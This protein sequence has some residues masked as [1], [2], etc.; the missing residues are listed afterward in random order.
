MT[1]RNDELEDMKR[2]DLAQYVASRGF[3]LDRRQSSRSS[4][5]MK[6]PSG[7]KLIIAKTSNGQFVYFNAKGNDN[8]TIID[9]IQARDRVSLGE[10]RKLLRLWLA[11]GGCS[12]SNLPTLPIVLQPSEH[13]A[14]Q[15]LTN[16][17]N[18]RPIG[19]TNAYLE[20]ERFI[21]AEIIRQPIFRDRIRVDNRNNT[22]FAHFNQSG[23]CGYEIK[24]TGWTGFAPGGI[25]G[26]ACS[27]PQPEDQ[28]MIV[29]ET[30]IDMLSYAALKGIAGK[31]FFSTAGQISPMQVD[32]LQSAANNMPETAI[33][34]LACDNDPGGHQLA[35]QI[36]EV[37]TNTGRRVTTDFPTATGA[38]WNDVLKQRHQFQPSPDF[39]AVP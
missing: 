23:L 14:A 28:T 15:V 31:R 36:Q 12:I 26:L 2:I 25:K 13:N 24:N 3:V 16:W 17:L 11:S 38:D 35:D 6:H 21:P 37:L 10:A 20:Q 32:C 30:A 39:P 22:L 29:C 8:G 4:L 27:R 1:S 34:I 7:D 19:Q 9:F 5:V 18:A 33:I